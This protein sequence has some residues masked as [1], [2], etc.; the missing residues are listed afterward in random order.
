MD[1]LSEAVG[2][3]AA[4]KTPVRILRGRYRGRTGRI[5]GDLESRAQRGITKAIVHIDDDVTLLPT[6]MLAAIAQ[7]ELALP[8]AETKTPPAGADGVKLI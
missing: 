5:A 2:H 4:V 1:P 7:L 8:A 3:G 6:S